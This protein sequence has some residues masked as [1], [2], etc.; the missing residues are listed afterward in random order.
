MK[1]VL[2]AN[3]T[4]S[5][6]GIPEESDVMAMR[7]KLSELDRDEKL[8][9]ASALTVTEPS[10]TLLKPNGMLMEIPGKTVT[11]WIV[12]DGEVYLPYNYYLRISD[13]IPNSERSHPRAEFEF[14][15]TLRDYQESIV[16]EALD[17]L[18]EFGTC[19]LNVPP[20]FGKT[21][22]ASYIA[23]KCGLKVLVI[24]P[25]KL[26]VPQWVNTF[27][28]FTSAEVTTSDYKGDMEAMDIIVTTTQKLKKIHPCV[29]DQIGTVIFDEAHMLCTPSAVK[30]LLA[31]QPMF[32]IACT[33]TY[34]R[35]DTMHNMMNL[36]V[37]THR[38]HRPLYREH[39]VVKVK[40]E[41]EPQVVPSKVAKIDWSIFAGSLW[42]IVERNQ[43]IVDLC[44]AHDDKFIAVFT[45]YVEHAELLA[46][47]LQAEGQDVDTLYAT[48]SKYRNCR[49]LI[50]TVP[51]GGTG[52]DQEAVCQA[53]DGNR[54]NMGILAFSTKDQSLLEQ[55][56]GR[57]FRTEDVP[58]VYD[59]V[60]DHT[61]CEKHWDIREDWYIRCGGSISYRSMK[62]FMC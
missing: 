60:D 21:V 5:L 48:K 24:A 13:E 3:I 2:W 37:G 42:P 12:K 25:R 16:D 62:S 52:F 23:R 10:K 61:K 47:M 6:A 53:F 18:E 34:S 43:F 27:S 36:I 58:L 22:M 31:T 44:I 14:K 9:I 20:A 7:L 56:V 51:K 45:S 29:L 26:L 4:D 35:S 40:T 15:G 50:I 33:A 19:T 1:F 38:V 30:I 41:F 49:V 8:K 46:R 55:V 32:V 39:T 11:M 17:H 54:F 57:L 59:I 28:R